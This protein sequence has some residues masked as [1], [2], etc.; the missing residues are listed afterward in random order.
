MRIPNWVLDAQILSIVSTGIYIKA[1]STL[2]VNGE[3]V[4]FK[5]IWSKIHMILIVGFSLFGLIMLPFILIAMIMLPVGFITHIKHHYKVSKFYKGG[6]KFNFYN[7][8]GTIVIAG[9]D[10]AWVTIMGIFGYMTL[11]TLAIFYLFN[12][13][14]T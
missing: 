7:T 8:L 2:R 1:R 14:L 6:K 4:H 9:G 3:Q 13:I 10:L 12:T 5:T 11:L